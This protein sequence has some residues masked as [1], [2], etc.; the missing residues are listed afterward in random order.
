MAQVTP[1]ASNPYVDRGRAIQYYQ[2]SVNRLKN[3]KLQ[4]GTDQYNKNAQRIRDIGSKYGFNWQKHIGS[5]WSANPTT[6]PEASPGAPSQPVQPPAEKQPD[7]PTIMANYSSPMTQALMNAF[8]QGTNTMRAYE[9]K[10]FEG[11]PL[12]QFQKQQGQ[13]DIEKLMAA[14]GLTNSGAEIDANSKFLNELGATEAEKQRQYAEAEAQRANNAMQFIANYDQGERQNLM[15]QLNTDLDRRNAL[16]Q[17]EARRQD[18]ARSQNV[19]T[20]L[21]ILGLQSKNDIASLA[22]NGLGQSSKYS[23][24]LMNAI[25]SNRA[26]SYPRA[27]A[28]LPPPRPYDT[29]NLDLARILMNYSGQA[30]QNAVW[31]GL[32]NLGTT[33]LRS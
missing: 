22:Y 14:R 1:A 32:F 18:E 17:F 13:R 11:S 27:S 4:P 28:G 8:K 7:I 23:Q 10:N 24:A 26:N 15:Q 20:L 9:P 6:P 30:D 33:Y 19:N 29:S 2:N 16:A 3:L 31:N 21:E 5:N 25:A 12:Y